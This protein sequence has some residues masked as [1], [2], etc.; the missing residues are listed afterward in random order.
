MKIQSYIFMDYV[1][2]RYGYTRVQ[3]EEIKVKKIT[4][5]LES[6]KEHLDIQPWIFNNEKT[7]HLVNNSGVPT[8]KAREKF[9]IKRDPTQ[10]DVV[11][12]NPNADYDSPDIKT[13]ECRYIYYRYIEDW[14]TRLTPD[15]EFI[16]IKINQLN[17]KPNDIILC[18]TAL[19]SRIYYTTYYS[20][21]KGLSE[22]IRTVEILEDS[23]KNPPERLYKPYERQR[24]TQI[25]YNSKLKTI[26]TFYNT[27]D[28]LRYLNKTNQVIDKAK[29]EELRKLGESRDESHL[30]IMMELMANCNYEKSYLYLL[31]L[32]KEF[33]YKFWDTRARHHVNFKSLL[34]YLELSDMYWRYYNLDLFKL[35]NTLKNKGM[36]TKENAEILMDY[37]KNDG[38][39]TETDA[40]TTG[41]KNTLMY[42]ENYLD[43]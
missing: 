34:D 4:G 43:L 25:P 21:N 11:F 38:I 17:P 39:V 12:I 41:W 16:R 33:S 22:S 19:Y 37:F 36:F 35:S 5:F 23:M 10:A 13:I 32:L 27:Q 20:A 15:Y 31:L 14:L 18:C 3:P 6:V 8:I 26:S 40:N 28:L 7:I 1:G 2:P 24:F 42:D 9:N 29:Y 30:V